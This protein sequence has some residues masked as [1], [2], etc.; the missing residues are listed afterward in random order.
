MRILSSFLSLLNIALDT[1]NIALDVAESQKNEAIK[2]EYQ[3]T[4]FLLYFSKKPSRVLDKDKYPHYLSYG[5]EIKD[6]SKFHQKMIDDGYF[7]H[8]SNEEKLSVLTIPEIK[9]I[10]NKFNLSGNGK[11]NVLIQRVIE[12]ISQKELARILPVTYSLSKKGLEYLEKNSD[13]IK[14]HTYNFLNISVEEY[15]SAKQENQ[16]FL[17]TI[18]R[19]LNQ[20]II[21]DKF[22]YGR[23]EYFQMYQLLDI[24][25]K[26]KEALEILLRIFYIDLRN[27]KN[28][29]IIFAPGIIKAIK[30]HQDV[31][32]EDM[33]ENLYQWKLS[34][35]CNKKLFIKFIHEIMNNSFN[36]QQAE[37]ELKA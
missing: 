21:Q 4:I 32:S 14:L 20:R 26:R 5:Y 7:S 15:A 23:R 3:K 12:N 22:N 27:A 24:E 13:Y 29:I 6:L 37:I 18:W 8:S 33:I 25:N 2:K 10:L 28:E 34:K 17:D 31:F 30:E 11:K 1:M 9:E 35:R 16:N 36:E 19:I